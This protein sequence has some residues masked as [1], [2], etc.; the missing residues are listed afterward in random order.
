VTLPAVLITSYASPALHDR[1]RGVQAA[2]VEK[3]LLGDALV[4][5]IRQA[6]PLP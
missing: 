1:A 6:L 5:Y 4:S 2:V 3:P